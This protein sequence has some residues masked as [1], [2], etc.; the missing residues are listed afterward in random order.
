MCRFQSYRCVFLSHV[1]HNSSYYT[2]IISYSIVNPLVMWYGSNVIEITSEDHFDCST[3]FLMMS[4]QMWAS[5]VK[6]TWK[7]KR[8]WFCL[9]IRKCWLVPLGHCADERLQPQKS[10]FVSKKKIKAFEKKV[11][12]K[13]HWCF[14]SLWTMF[15]LTTTTSDLFKITKMPQVYLNNSVGR[16]DW[17]YLHVT[18]QH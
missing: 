6:E 3:V 9:V 11:L 12:G 18:N 7:W 16:T 4:L 14:K 1:S 15:V 2:L 17:I 13:S 10:D 8:V 5:I